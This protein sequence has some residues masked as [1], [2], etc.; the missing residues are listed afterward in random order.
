MLRFMA[1]R[2]FGCLHR[3]PPEYQQLDL[4]TSNFW[5]E[6]TAS[7]M[8]EASFEDEFECG[9]NSRMPKKANH[10]K[11]PCSSVMRRLKRKGYY[12]KIRGE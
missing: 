9:R 4:L 6:R 7:L 8:N 2:A 3:A 11:R 10:G 5:H 12:H 1:K